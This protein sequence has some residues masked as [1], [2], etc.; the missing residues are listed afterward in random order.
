MFEVA[1]VTDT[2][3]FCKRA[4]LEAKIGMAPGIAFGKGAETPYP[5]VLRQKRRIADAGDGPAGEFRRQLR[6]SLMGCDPRTLAAL[7]KLIGFDTVSRNSNLECIDWARAHME[8]HGARTRMDWNAD[9]SK[10][11]MLATFGEGPGG[12]VLSG[13]VD[14]VP[15]DGQD[16]TSDPFTA[17]IRDGRRLWPRRLRHEGI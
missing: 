2:L 12:V 11:N 1:G 17:T 4:V 8:A 6:R 10:A 14:V 7:E 16:W 15:V 5:A 9:R 3:N 13:H